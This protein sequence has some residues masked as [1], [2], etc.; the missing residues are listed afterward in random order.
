LTGLVKRDLAE[1]REYNVGL[2]DG[3]IFAEAETG[4]YRTL[5]QE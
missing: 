5:L 3:R 2:V 1:I 4:R